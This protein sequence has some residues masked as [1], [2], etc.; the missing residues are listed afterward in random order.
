[1]GDRIHFVQEK[2]TVTS[3]SGPRFGPLVSWKTYLY[4]WTLRLWNLD[5]FWSV[6]H[7]L[8]DCKL[9]LRRLLVVHILVI[10]QLHPLRFRAVICEADDPCSVKTA[11]APESYFTFLLGPPLVLC[12]FGALVLTPHS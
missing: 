7:F 12:I 1:M 9:I 11:H 8:F 2:S 10:S 6:F 4:M 3:L 5:L